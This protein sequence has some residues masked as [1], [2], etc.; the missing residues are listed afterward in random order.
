M[1]E[2]LLFLRVLYGKW[3]EM[4]PFAL[5]RAAALCVRARACVAFVF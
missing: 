4:V 2:G 3:G 1:N 5:M